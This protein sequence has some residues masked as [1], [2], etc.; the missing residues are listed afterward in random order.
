VATQIISFYSVE[1]RKT[2]EERTVLARV[3]HVTKAQVLYDP[4]AKH[5]LRPGALDQSVIDGKIY[6][7]RQQDN[8]SNTQLPN[9]TPEELKR[10]NARLRRGGV[11]GT[12]NVGQFRS[13]TSD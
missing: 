5:D 2:I 7:L 1:L 13:P 4:Y 6:R 9:K 10:L 3:Q 12:D 11:A 8:L